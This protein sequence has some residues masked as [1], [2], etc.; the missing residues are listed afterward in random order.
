[1]N[2]VYIKIEGYSRPGKNST[3]IASPTICLINAG[4]KK[5]LVDLGA[6]EKKLISVL[7]KFKISKSDISFVYL[8]HYHPDHFLKLKK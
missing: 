1:M 4:A 8:S 6:N 2:K 5:I 3:Y 7:K